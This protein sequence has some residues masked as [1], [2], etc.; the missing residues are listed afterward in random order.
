MD[1]DENYGNYVLREHNKFLRDN[2]LN[3]IIII[4]IFTGLNVGRFKPAISY[5][6]FILCSSRFDTLREPKVFFLS[7]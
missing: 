1:G 3:M 5:K 4:I 6:S 7:K 2:Q